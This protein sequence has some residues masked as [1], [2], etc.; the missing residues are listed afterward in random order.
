MFRILYLAYFSASMEI[1]QLP[2]PGNPEGYTNT[3]YPPQGRS[4]ASLIASSTSIYIFGG[5]PL[6][7]SEVWIYDM[8]KSL[9]SSFDTTISKYK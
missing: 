7:Y 1:K 8:S 5:Y 6:Q 3:G 4:D 2:Y 9:W